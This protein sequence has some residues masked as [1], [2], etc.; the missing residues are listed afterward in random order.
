[1]K[2]RVVPRVPDAFEFDPDQPRDESGKWTGD[3]GSSGSS[4]DAKP[5]IGPPLPAEVER[6]TARFDAKAREIGP[7]WGQD[8]EKELDRLQDELMKAYDD[9]DVPDSERKSGFERGDGTRYG[10]PPEHD[11]QD[12]A[13]P[14]VADEHQPTDG[15]ANFDAEKLQKEYD[16][17]TDRSVTP[18]KGET[19][20]SDPDLKGYDTTE[21]WSEL[22][23]RA[24]DTAPPPVAAE[25][26][27]KGD[28]DHSSLRGSGLRFRMSGRG[29][30]RVGVEAFVPKDERPPDVDL[31]ELARVA[32][33]HAP[34]G[35][36]GETAWNGRDRIVFWAPADWTTDEELDA[37]EEAFLAVPGVEGVEREAEAALPAGEGWEVVWTPRPA[38]APSS[39]EESAAERWD[40]LARAIEEDEEEAVVASAPSFA[41]SGTIAMMAAA[42]EELEA[43]RRRE[44]ELIQA[45]RRHDRSVLQE[46]MSALR[47]LAGRPDGDVHVTLPAQE[48]H[49]HVTVHE[50]SI[51]VEPSPAPDVSVS[52]EPTPVQVAAPEVTVEPRIEVA[53]TP[54]TVDAPVTVE[55]AAPPNVQV[56]V[57]AEPR[58]RQ[59]RA[60]KAED[61]TTTFEVVGD[62]L[63]AELGG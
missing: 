16:T 3:G 8:D 18:P 58:P 55:A 31:T 57:E 39:A 44:F 59:I 63:G 22:R 36:Y 27:P 9:H 37:A 19:R 30:R 49:P 40:R 13:P 38:P 17:R 28:S 5:T 23:D 11:R 34:E 24:Q 53:P 48:I 29:M 41:A 45:S 33:A 62:E 50:P 26:Q 2:A 56:T 42:A 32:E 4:G 15:L 25:H 52:V 61:G 12:T 35:G 14:P 54:V 6:A 47:A 7:M 60:T 21:L 10:I 46:A 1:V 43:S 20:A 51:T